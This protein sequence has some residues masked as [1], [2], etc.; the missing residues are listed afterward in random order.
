MT[1]AL[2]DG[3]VIVYQA[4]FACQKTHYMLDGMV[5]ENKP[6]LKQYIAD[7]EY[8]TD[9][10]YEQELI[11][12]DIANALHTVKVMLERIQNEA[13]CDSREVYLTGKGNYR[14]RVYPAYKANRKDMAKPVLYEDIREYMIKYHA[15]QVI[16]G[17]EAD[18]ALG[19][20][21][22]EDTVICTI[23]KDLDTVPGPHYNWR[24][25]DQGVYHVLPEAALRFTYT[26]I[27]MG[28]AV[29]NIPG[30]P[31][32]G[33]KK[34][35]GLLNGANSS[36]EYQK[37]ILDAYRQHPIYK[38]CTDAELCDTIETVAN[39]IIIRTNTEQPLW[40]LNKQAVKEVIGLD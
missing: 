36:Y 6:D 2:I 7:N 38:E 35:Q 8:C 5:F 21:Q 29:D 37:I 10:E 40:L 4:G 12:E 26:Q 13:G 1:T 34:A 20:N 17:Q 39:L 9:V 18:D 11:V 3:D 16:Q 28:D 30:L 23:D 32:I 25:P 27:L 24:K 14:N 19:I 15:A 33:I 31:G 22:G